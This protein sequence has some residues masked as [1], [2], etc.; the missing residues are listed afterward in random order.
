MSYEKK[1]KKQGLIYC[2]LEQEGITIPR[3]VIKSSVGS[4]SLFRK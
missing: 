1:N 3:P 4:M 2:A